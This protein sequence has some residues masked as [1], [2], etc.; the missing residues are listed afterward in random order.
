MTPKDN[1]QAFFYPDAVAVIGASATPGKVGHTIVTNM[2]SAG[3]TGKLLPVNPKGGT[4]EGL[5]VVTDINDLPRGLDLAVISVPP[6]AVVE[7]VRSLGAIGT[8]SAIV[9]TAGFKEAGKEGYDLEQALKAA[10]E[11]YG[12][13]LLGPN[14][15]GMINGA[16]GVN[17]SFAASLPGLG[18][19]AFFSQS[20]ALCV[21]ILDWALGAN[22]GFSKFISLGNKAVLDEADMLEYL[23]RD[24]AT[25]VILGYIENVE[26]GE[27]FLKQARR[28]SLNKPVIMIKAGTTAAGAKAASS[29]TG[30]IAGSD[31]SYTAAFHQS[32]VIRVGDVASL[33]N[34]AQAFSNQPLPKGPNLAVVTNAGGPGIL[35]ADA[36]DRSRLSM[37]ELSPRTIEKLQE[38]LPSYAAFYNPVDIVADA[39]AKR[40]RQTLD[41]IGEDPMVHSILVLLT[42]TAS[43]EIEKAAE[44]VIRTARKWSKP[45]FAC[46]MGKIRVAGARRMLMEAG[47]P[48]YAFPE[49]A[50]R[51]IETM[52]QYYLWKNRPEPEYAEVERDMEAVRRVIDDHLRRRQAEV[53]EFEARH[54]LEA[55]NLPTPKTR[56]AR[57]SEE[58]V[59]AAEEIGYPV[60]LKIASPNISHKTDVGGVKINLYNAAEVEDSFKEITARAQRMRRDAYIAGCLVQEMAPPGVREVII[61]FKR[62]EQFGPML[63][64]GLGGVYV[65]I[66]KDISFKLA[67]LSRQDAFEIVREIKSYMLLKGLKGEKPVN[68]AALER[69]IMVMSRLAQDLP[70]VLEAEFNPVLVNHERAMVAD[71]RMTLSV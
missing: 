4:I 47:V 69:I 56:L 40:Y 18:S 23:N 64:F 53:V 49:P 51:S 28:A 32:G 9:I 8:K 67:P 55:Y 70:E 33:F 52:Y 34:L 22:I 30:A 27:A 13:S 44:A 19:I 54:V 3:Y 71:V 57:T 1:L 62:D 31:Q 17:A 41:V 5:P 37:A 46:F 24:E 16:A 48:C 7:A 14:C 60:V 29:H 12:I 58:A 36:A 59:A 42:P 65:E 43:V 11:E 35:A 26:H 50:V 10:C 63:M 39:D 68:F 38:F 66:M 25:K 45:V 6:A 61:G 2:L 20:G 21:A 15:L